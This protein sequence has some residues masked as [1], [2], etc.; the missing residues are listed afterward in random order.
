MVACAIPG[1]FITGLEIF[2]RQ[3][4]DFWQTF[5]KKKTYKRSQA[6]LRHFRE[7]RKDVGADRFWVRFFLYKKVL[8]GCFLQKRLSR[9]S[10]TLFFIFFLPVLLVKFVGAKK[11]IPFFP[12]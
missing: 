5:E 6:F 4:G 3:F 12:F 8:I 1:E 9:S 2:L 11:N 10:V 7:T